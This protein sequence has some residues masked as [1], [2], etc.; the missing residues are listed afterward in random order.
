[1]FICHLGLIFL[2]PRVASWR[3]KRGNRSLAENL[4]AGDGKIFDEKVE[5]NI[6][7]DDDI[8][9]P[10]EI[11]EVIDELMIGLRNLDRVVR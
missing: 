1:M 2:K 3:Y 11:E 9:V 6:E 7:S 8:E 10:D 4:S 5:K